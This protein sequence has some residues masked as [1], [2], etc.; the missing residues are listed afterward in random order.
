MWKTVRKPL[1]SVF[2]NQTAEIEF[3]VFEFCGQFGSF[4]F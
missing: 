4:S 2:E 1:K 3:A